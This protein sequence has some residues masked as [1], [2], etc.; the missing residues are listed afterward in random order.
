MVFKMR[1]QFKTGIQIRFKGDEVPVVDP[2]N[3]SPDPMGYF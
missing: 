3:V 1:R 2:D